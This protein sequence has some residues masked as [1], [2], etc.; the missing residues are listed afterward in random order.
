MIC[1]LAFK[2]SVALKC[3]TNA[4]TKLDA[5]LKEDAGSSQGS[6]DGHRLPH[7]TA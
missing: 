2:K 4:L 6:E 3:I 7:Y 1:V 5:A